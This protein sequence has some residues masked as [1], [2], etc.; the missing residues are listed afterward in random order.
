[1]F[2]KEAEIQSQLDHKHL[3]GFRFFREF[4]NYLCLGMELCLGGT[5]TDW[6]IDQRKNIHNKSEEDHDK[7]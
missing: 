7:D 1:M 2:K 4:H 6:I 5:L 3:I